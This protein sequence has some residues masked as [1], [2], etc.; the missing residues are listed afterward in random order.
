MLRAYARFSKCR[1]ASLGKNET[2]RDGTPWRFRLGSPIRGRRSCTNIPI[3]PR[4][5][6]IRCGRQIAP[7]SRI[8]PSRARHRSRSR[9]WKRRSSGQ[10]TTS[11]TSRNCF[12]PSRPWPSRALVIATSRM[13]HAG[14]GFLVGS[15]VDGTISSPPGCG[16]M[17]RRC[18]DERNHSAIASSCGGLHRRVRSV[19]PCADTATAGSASPAIR[20]ARQ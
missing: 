19:R 15:H 1:V 6:M 10:R 16:A 11:V 8:G 12:G 13:L 17:R 4:M 3:V 9:A 2:P 5:R 18:S 7:Q 14:S 20:P